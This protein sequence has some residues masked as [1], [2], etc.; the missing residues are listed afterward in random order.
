VSLAGGD[1]QEALPHAWRRTGVRCTKVKPERAQ[2]SMIAFV[3]SLT[4]EGAY[5]GRYS[6]RS[7]RKVRRIEMTDKKASTTIAN[8]LDAA[9]PL[10]A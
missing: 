8:S 7:L 4:R 2:A 5:R 3:N 10:G 1:R 9:H 6:D